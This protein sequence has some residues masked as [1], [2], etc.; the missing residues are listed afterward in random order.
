M[1][2]PAKSVTLMPTIS[3]VRDC[4]SPLGGAPF[5]TRSI[6][7]AQRGGLNLPPAGAGFARDRL[8]GTSG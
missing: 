3:V 6:P 4:M 8:D 5:E 2:I 7:T 1:A